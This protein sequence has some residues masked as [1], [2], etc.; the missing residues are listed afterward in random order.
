MTVLCVCVLVS[1]L[2]MPTWLTPACLEEAAN[3]GSQLPGGLDLFLLSPINE[4]IIKRQLGK[5]VTKSSRD[6][7]PSTS[8]TT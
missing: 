4:L 5:D 7:C 8:Q 3:F 2:F 6:L 1:H